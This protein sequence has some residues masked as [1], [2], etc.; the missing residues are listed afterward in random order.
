MY[1][2]FKHTEQLPVL[3][4]LF[5]AA[6]FYWPVPFTQLWSAFMILLRVFFMAL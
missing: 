6:S 1:N 2:Y 3:T 4:Y 5:A